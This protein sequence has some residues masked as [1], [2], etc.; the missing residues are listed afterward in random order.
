MPDLG[1][2]TFEVLSSYA[3]TLTLL[4]G[5]VF[6]SLRRARKVRAYLSDIEY[7]RDK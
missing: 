5:I 2:Y 7:R 6:V 1:T 4:A 3:V